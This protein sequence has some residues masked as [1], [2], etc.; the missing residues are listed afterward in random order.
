MESPTVNCNN[1]N[2]C[3]NGSGITVAAG[4]RLAHFFLAGGTNTAWLRVRAEGGGTK[5]AWLG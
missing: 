3:T 1:F 4:T 5:T 2:I